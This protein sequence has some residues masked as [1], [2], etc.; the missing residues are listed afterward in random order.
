M[1]MFWITK[2]LKGIVFFIVFAS[3]FSFLVMWLWNTIVPGITGWKMLT[4]WEAAGLLLLSKILFGFRGGWGRHWGGHP[5]HNYF[6]KQK[7]DDKLS[8]MTPEERE[9]M[10]NMWQQ[11]FCNWQEEPKQSSS[12]NQA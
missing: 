2:I 12:E 7:W 10:K 5:R 6:W 3:L 11:R 1:K 4:F 8:H 9:K